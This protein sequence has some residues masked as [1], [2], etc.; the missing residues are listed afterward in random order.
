MEAIA[1]S[2]TIGR[3]RLEKLLNR[4]LSARVGIQP[5]EGLPS[6]FVVQLS[7]LN[8]LLS[9]APIQYKSLGSL[10]INCQFFLHP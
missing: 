3:L 6:L 7:G 4:T 2:V 1:P 9:A 5:P 10:S 8:H